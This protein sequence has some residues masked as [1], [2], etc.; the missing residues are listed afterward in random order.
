MFSL[1][2]DTPK[3][4]QMKPAFHLLKILNIEEW[5]ENWCAQYLAL[6]G[7]SRVGTIQALNGKEV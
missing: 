4:A 6:S 2:L 1:C 7:G 3:M 5:V